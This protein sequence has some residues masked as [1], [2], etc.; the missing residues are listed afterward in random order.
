MKGHEQTVR[1]YNEIGI[2]RFSTIR[3]SHH[4]GDP[5]KMEKVAKINA[6]TRT[7]AFAYFLEKLSSRLRTATARC[8]II[9]SSF[10]AAV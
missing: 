1:S 10:M 4:G 7:K 3:L 5:E 2:F 8:W 9:R 6:Y